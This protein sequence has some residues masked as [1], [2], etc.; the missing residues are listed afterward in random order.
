[1]Q[2]ANTLPENLAYGIQ[3]WKLQCIYFDGRNYRFSRSHAAV[4]PAMRGRI[5]VPINQ[6]LKQRFASPGELQAASVKGIIPP[7]PS[8]SVDLRTLLPRG[9]CVY[10]VVTRESR[11]GQ[12]CHLLVLFPAGGEI[13]SFTAAAGQLL[14]LPL[15]HG[16]L[17]MGASRAHAGAQLVTRLAIAL[18]QDA[19]ALTHQS[20]G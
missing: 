11:T 4:D 16:H 15:E 10:T 3:L 12:N 8:A 20:L 6:A 13:L 18:Y 14:G 19:R 7:M 2:T 9:S 17:R 5:A 1:M